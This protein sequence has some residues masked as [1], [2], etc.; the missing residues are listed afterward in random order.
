MKILK[1]LLLAIGGIV[2][3]V[4]IAAVFMPKTYMVERSVVIHAP[5][6]LIMEQIKNLKKANEWS[7]FTEMDPQTQI[8]YSG[9]DGEV[10]S[11]SHWKSEQA[12]EGSQTITRISPD[13]VDISLHFKEPFESSA[14]A[15]FQ[16]MSQGED[17]KVSWGMKGEDPY[18]LNFIIP[19]M[20]GMLGKEFEKGLNKLKARCE[21]MASQTQ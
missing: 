6:A 7:P 3:I 5:Q 1:Y 13:R 18:P 4:L 8:T 2:A 17:N 14:S 11:S 19:F 16:A 15:Y 12:G 9:T 10:G 21:G 20:D